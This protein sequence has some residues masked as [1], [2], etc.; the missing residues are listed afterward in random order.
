MTDWTQVLTNIGFDVPLGQ[1]QFQILCPFHSDRVKSCSLNTEK[2]V[3][4]CFAGCG[5]GSL[6]TFIKKYKNWSNEQI[7]L[8]LNKYKTDYDD[9]FNFELDEVDSILPEVQIPYTQFKVPNWIFDRGFNKSTLKKWKCGVTGNNGLVIPVEDKDLRTVGWIVRQEKNIPKYLYSTGL[10]KSKL[11]FGQSYIKPCN[12]IYVTE[13]A[14]D[15]MWMD[16]LGYP[17]VALLGMNMSK[18]QRELLLT[19]PTKEI[20]LCLD[21][22]DAGEIGRNN[23]LDSLMGK[24]TLSYIKLPKEYKDVQEIKSCD[25]LKD[26][27][28][29]RRYW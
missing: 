4:I 1:D 27:I 21:N 24:I 29:N 7:D 18:T 16:Q 22:D 28:K 17:S 14:L 3:W 10:K 20:I 13:G 15:A 12:S 5:Q 2:G 25:I 11:L 19:L 8:F 23:I 9:I 26:I 6:I